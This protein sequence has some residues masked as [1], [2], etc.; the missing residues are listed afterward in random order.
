[1]TMI[2]YERRTYE[3]WLGQPQLILKLVHNYFAPNNKSF[4]WGVFVGT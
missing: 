3:Q 2:H 1:M 4:A